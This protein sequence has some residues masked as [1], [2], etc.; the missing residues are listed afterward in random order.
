M[1]FDGYKMISYNLFS[2]ILLATYTSNMFTSDYQGLNVFFFFF[3]IIV[4][5][6]MM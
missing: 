6:I 2:I 1:M 3:D 4:K 5:T